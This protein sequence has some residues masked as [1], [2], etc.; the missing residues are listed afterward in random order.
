MMDDKTFRTDPSFISCGVLISRISSPAKNYSRE[1]IKKEAGRE[2]RG[3]RGGGGGVKMTR[4]EAEGERKAG[5][6]GGARQSLKERGAPRT[7][8]N[9]KFE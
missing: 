5:N 8:F 9:F 3:G 2:G 6:R 1:Q 7:F 4:E